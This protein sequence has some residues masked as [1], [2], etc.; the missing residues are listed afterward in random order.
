MWIRGNILLSRQM[1]ITELGKRFSESETEVD[2][3]EVVI[4][5]R[6]IPFFAE[7]KLHLKPQKNKLHYKLYVPSLGP[8]IFFMYLAVIFLAGFTNWRMLVVGSIIVT[9]IAFAI[10]VIN[11]KGARNYLHKHIDSIADENII[12]TEDVAGEGQCPACKTQINPYSKVC[13]ECG[14]HIKNAKKPDSKDNN[15]ASGTTKIHYHFKK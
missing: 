10:Y 8:L 12:I 9:G 7:H 3:R 5:T 11:D 4:N 14:L 6:N 2:E 15:T 1:N 13:P